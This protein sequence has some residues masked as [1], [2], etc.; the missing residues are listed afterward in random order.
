MRTFAQDL[1]FALRQL[2]RSPLFSLTV[3]LTL[4]LSIGAA[5]ALVAALRATLLSSLPYPRAGE[6]VEVTDQNLLGVPSTGLVGLPRVNDLAT[7]TQPRAHAVFAGIAAFYSNAGQLAATGVEPMPTQGAA[8]SSTFFQTCGVAAALGRALTASDDLP[9]AAPVVVLSDHLWRSS[10]IVLGV[11]PG[12]FDLPTAADLWYPAHLGAFRFGS[13]RGE[14]TRFI[15]VIARLTPGTSVALARQAVGVLAQQLAAAY[16]ATDAAWGLSLRPLRASLFGPLR[17]GLLLL[18]AAV[19]LVLL[20]VVVNIAGLQLARNAQR[21][22][23]FAIRAALGISRP[24]L[25]L[26][27]ATESTLLVATGSLAGLALAA[28]ALQLLR[29]A[30][31]ASLFLV[32]A[33]H[34]GIA[35]IVTTAGLA[36]AIDL[37]LAMLSLA[38]HPLGPVRT[39]TRRPRRF[40]RIL[41]AAQISLT[42]VLLSLSAAV[43]GSLYHLLATPLGFAPSHVLTGTIDLGWNIPNADR[44]RFYEQTEATIASLPGVESVG[45]STALPLNSV[46]LRSTFDV[47]GQAPT[48]NHDTITAESRAITPD[49]SRTLGIPLLAGRLFTAQDSLPGAP[50]VL[51]VNQTFARRYFPGIGAVGQRLLSAG[52]NAGAP[53]RSSEI[54]AVLADVHGTSGALAPAPTPEV[55]DPEQGNW[56]HMQFAIRTALPAAALE[57]V[58]RRLVASRDRSASVSHLT[59]LSAVVNQSLAQPRWNAALL[60]AFAAL[61]LLL[62]I[63]GIYGLVAFEVTTRTRELAVRLALGATRPAILR[64]LLRQSATMLLCGLTAGMLGSAVSTHLLH[65]T[66]SDLLGPTSPALVLGTVLLL[67][68]AVLGATLVPARRA[69]QIEPIQALRSE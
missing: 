65:A 9:A 38:R 64:L 36:L 41:T 5:A 63:L 24:R 68:A 3:I 50:P 47:A 52:Y 42:L 37:L 57:P 59:E 33:P 58:L 49:Y 43:L 27:L 30:L 46:N 48:P 53:L 12:T 20:V 55:Y 8:V 45:A 62:V 61:S 31:P 56:P 16:P 28:L 22:P 15:R 29:T 13:Y 40:G 11:M 60:T 67:A 39:T 26:Q 51:A 18:S 23:E 4:A 66:S 1:G 32:Q 2:R 19:G 6:L 14:G 34:L 17:Q 10:F 25:L 69:T 54:V 7:L 21:A 35:T 44:H